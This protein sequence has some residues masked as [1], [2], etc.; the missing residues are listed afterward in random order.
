MLQKKGRVISLMNPIF[1]G[2]GVNKKDKGIYHI[3][4]GQYSAGRMVYY[5]EETDK[6]LK[7]KKNKIGRLVMTNWYLC[8]NKSCSS[9]SLL[10]ATGANSMNPAEIVAADSNKGYGSYGSYGYH[11]NF[12]GYWINQAFQDVDSNVECMNKI[13]TSL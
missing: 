1:S 3:M 13:N 5:N 10:S 7:C 9:F 6:Y 11:R 8:Q 2:I 12:W 4:G